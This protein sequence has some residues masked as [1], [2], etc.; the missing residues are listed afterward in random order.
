M[1]N[2]PRVLL[3]DDEVPL[4]D[5][6]A[7]WLEDEYDVETAY[8]GEEALETIDSEID[9]VLLDR[10]MPRVSGDE[11]L[12]EIRERELECRVAM[13]TAVDPEL[14]IFEMPFD[15]Y[16][17]KPVSEDELK[18]VIDRLYRLS[19][20]DRQ[21]QQYFSLVSKRVTIEAEKR[22]EELRSSEGCTRLVDRIE[23]LEGEL[24]TVYENFED[25]DLEAVFSGF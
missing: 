20:Y 24:D 25:R 18:D 22:P 4:A 16:L 19:E 13:V 14:D 23:S 10:R 7:A 2:G 12:E 11:V 9:V 6:Y 5:L 1:D 3:V 17:P 21:I 8:G 15:D